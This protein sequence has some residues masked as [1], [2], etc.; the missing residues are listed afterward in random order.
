MCHTSFGWAGSEISRIEVPLNSI[1]PVIAFSSGL[2]SRKLSWCPTYTQLP[3]AGSDF[4]VTCR[5]V[6]PW[7]SLYPIS[8]TFC[9]SSDIGSGAGALV[10]VQDARRRKPEARS[11]KPE[12]E[13]AR[14]LPASSFPLLPSSFWLLA[15]G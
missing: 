9:A 5:A 3:F 8:R 12:V 11:Q 7:R 6:R 2:P 14:P 1:L 4:V 10:L 13:Q 15:S